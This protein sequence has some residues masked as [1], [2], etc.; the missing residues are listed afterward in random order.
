MN[1]RA[2]KDYFRAFRFKQ[3]VTGEKIVFSGA[4]HLLFLVPPWTEYVLG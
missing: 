1:S 3:F 4:F 2:V